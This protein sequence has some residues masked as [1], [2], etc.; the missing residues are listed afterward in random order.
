M[1]KAQ[2]K[3]KTSP[4][5]WLGLA[6][7]LVVIYLVAFPADDAK[8]PVK[9]KPKVTKKAAGDIYTA[10]DRTAAE[11]P[12]ARLTGPVVD[13]FKPV[14][15]RSGGGGVVGGFPSILGG[16]AGWTYSGMATVDGVAKGLLENTNTGESVFL[17]KG[18]KWENA[19]AGEIYA[20]H[21]V[22][23]GPDGP[24]S[25]NVEEKDSSANTPVGAAS[26]SLPAP[27]API[28]VPLRGDIGT[29][30]LGL[31]VVPDTTTSNT[32]RRGRRNAS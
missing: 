30:D 7:G 15:L 14:I 32:R 17:S 10:A 25:V 29:Q 24:V 18:D 23:I 21:I 12:F 11:H 13:A 22:L 19:R 1:A 4:V 16:G 9:A 27:S 31:N 26:T 20:D 6:G 28:T 3:K 5:T 8:P 2:P